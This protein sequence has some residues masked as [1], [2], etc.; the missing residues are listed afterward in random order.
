VFAHLNYG[1]KKLI[2]ELCA[3]PLNQLMNQIYGQFTPLNS[4]HK[5]L[6]V[7]LGVWSELKGA[8]DKDFSK[9]RDQKIIKKFFPC[10][11]FRYCATLT[12]FVTM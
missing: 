6:G 11:D 12:S 4:K 5:M 7:M 1:F 2:N 8:W 3:K 9:N 10:L